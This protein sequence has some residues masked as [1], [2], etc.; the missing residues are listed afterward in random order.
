MDSIPDIWSKYTRWC[1]LLILLDQGG[2]SIC[3]DILF[4][5][6]IKNAKDGAEIYSKLKPH[7]EKIKKMGFYHQETLLPNNGVIDKDKVDI[8]LSTHIIQILDKKNTYSLITE[9]RIMINRLLLLP[10]WKRDITEQQ[11]EDSWAKISELL[12]NLDYNVNLIKGLKTEDLL[13]QEHENI[14]KDIS[15]KISGSIDL[16]QIFFLLFDIF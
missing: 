5:L 14:L 10:E 8:S 16:I 9:L 15:Q 6:G 13:P 11:F 3:S 1:R 4:K 7:R 12:H 2:K